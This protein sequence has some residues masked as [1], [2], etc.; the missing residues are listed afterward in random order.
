MVLGDSAQRIEH[1]RDLRSYDG[2]PR[3]RVRYN[4]KMSD[5]TAA[6][7]RVQLR[8]L[9]H[10][11]RR[12]RQLAKRYLRALSGGPWELPTHRAGH[13]YHRFV[14]RSRQ[15]TR[16]LTEIEKKGVD[17]RR[18]VFKPLHR[19]LGLEGFPGAEEAYQK[20]VSIPLYPAL[21]RR[22]AEH[23]IESVAKSGRIILE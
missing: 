5:I 19:Y 12:R 18:P 23:V 16:L 22:E 8:R 4:Y 10:F 7:G 6:L 2:R 21:T 15:T 14:L 13:V 3:L 20:A 9:N 1:I 11:I 17:A